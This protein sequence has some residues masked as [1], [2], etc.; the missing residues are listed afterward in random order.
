MRGNKIQTGLFTE[1]TTAPNKSARYTYAATKEVFRRGLSGCENNFEDL[2][3]FDPHV[4]E[5]KGDAL[6]RTLVVLEAELS[7][8]VHCVQPTILL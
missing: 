5:Y 2:T 1:T 4:S 6:V 7:I 3:H 8:C